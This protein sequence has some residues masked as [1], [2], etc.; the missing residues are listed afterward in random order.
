MSSER[1]LPER[2]DESLAIYNHVMQRKRQWAPRAPRRITLQLTHTSHSAIKTQRPLAR[3]AF[4]EATIRSARRSRYAQERGVKAF[5]FPFRHAHRCA[6]VSTGRRAQVSCGVHSA[7]II[8]LP[9]MRAHVMVLGL[10]MLWLG[11]VMAGA[12]RN[13]AHIFQTLS[14]GSKMV[15]TKWRLNTKNSPCTCNGG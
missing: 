9:G 5:L 4:S 12:T 8:V 7:A 13:R 1:R 10:V 11:Y 6:P 2:R 3:A 15:G 14:K